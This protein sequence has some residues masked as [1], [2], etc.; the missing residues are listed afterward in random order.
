MTTTIVVYVSLGAVGA[1]V[2]V[3]ISYLITGLWDRRRLRRFVRR[4]W[5]VLDE[6][7]AKLARRPK[8]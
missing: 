7:R 2:G 8:R 4:A 6:D 3:L 5:A 1:G